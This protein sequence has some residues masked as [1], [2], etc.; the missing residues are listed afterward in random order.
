MT[1]QVFDTRPPHPTDPPASAAS[2]VFGGIWPAGGFYSSA[3]FIER[4]P[5]T[6]L[7][8]AQAGVKTL[9]YIHSQS[10]EEIA[11]QV[12]EVFLAGSRTGTWL[13]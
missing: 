7:A 11:L 1:S 12:P 6:V 8:L 4:N 2:Q 10:A 9:K 13:R 3:E 5:H